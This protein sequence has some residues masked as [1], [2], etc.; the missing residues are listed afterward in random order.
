MSGYRCG[1]VEQGAGIGEKVVSGVLGIDASFE[2]MSYERNFP[3]GEWKGVA[4][5]DLQ[6]SSTP[7]DARWIPKK[8]GP[9]I[10]TVPDRDR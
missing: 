4:C 5:G 3:L 10:A 8:D 9:L 6:Y 7:G 2:G 1:K